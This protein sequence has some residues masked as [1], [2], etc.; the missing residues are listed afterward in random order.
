MF[1]PLIWSTPTKLPLN[2]T[3]TKKGLLQG[4]SKAVGI[5]EITIQVVNNEKQSTSKKFI[6]NIKNIPIPTPINFNVSVVN[7]GGSNVYRID[8]TNQST[9]NLVRGKTY[10]FTLNGSVNTHPFRIKTVS[11]GGN[12]LTNDYNNGVNGNGSQSGKITFVVPSNAPNTLYYTCGN[13]SG[14]GGTINIT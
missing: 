6:L 2:L 12:G 10:T 11:G 14:M 4:T 9:L 7:T 8:G 5:F 13:H 1:T 3:L